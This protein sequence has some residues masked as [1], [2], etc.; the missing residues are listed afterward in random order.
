MGNRAVITAS[1]D[2]NAPCIYL[3]WNGGRASVEAFLAAAKD[4]GL[5]GTSVETFDRFAQILAKHFFD[6]EVGMTVYRQRYGESDKDNYDNGTYLIDG[7]FKIVDR[8]FMKRPDGSVLFEEVDPDKTYSIH[9]AI[10]K[11]AQMAEDQSTDAEDVVESFHFIIVTAKPGGKGAICFS[12][13]KADFVELAAGHGWAFQAWED[14]P[15]L[16]DE[17]QGH[18]KFAG[19]YGPMWDGSRIRYEDQAAY[20]IL[21]T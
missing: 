18:A 11:N 9:E 6:C 5:S 2:K 4:L 16:R 20:D 14:A 1:T 15:H 3:H 10:V 8:L 7:D 21:S 17:L 13:T 12:G 19:L